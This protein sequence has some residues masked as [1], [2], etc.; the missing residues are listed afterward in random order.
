MIVGEKMQKN[1]LVT[2]ES[3]IKAAGVLTYPSFAAS[4]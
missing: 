3:Q 1:S 2:P 4:V